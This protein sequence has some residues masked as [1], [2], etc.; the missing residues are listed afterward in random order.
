MGA[1]LTLGST[2]RLRGQPKRSLS[3]KIW[4][5]E[6]AASHSGCRT[7]AAA[8]LKRALRPTGHDLQI[9]YGETPQSFSAT[10]HV[11]GRTAWPKRVLEGFAGQSPINPVRDVNLLL[12]DGSVSG[13]TA[14]FAYVHIATVP[15]AKFLAE[16]QASES[17][18]T[19]YDYSAPAA[20]TQL[21]VHEVG[22]ALGLDHDHGSVTVD[23][24]SV[25]A[26]P[27]VSG[28]AWAPE[29]TRHHH[30]DG[31]ACGGSLESVGDR[32]RRLSMRFSTCAEAAIRSYRA[33]L[34]F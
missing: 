32:K 30:W 19:I 17:S 9:S 25:T 3:I 6:G 31:R 24:S 20:V 7:L 18:E 12:T 14:G 4:V 5:T 21:L 1:A 23:E 10:G 2:G 22:H 26:S 13:S 16:M 33:G 15:G 8:Y 29:R 27:M 28:Y 34:P 11:I